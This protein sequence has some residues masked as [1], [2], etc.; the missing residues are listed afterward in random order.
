M[1]IILPAYSGKQIV[2]GDLRIFSSNRSF[3]F[4]KRMIEVSVNHLLLQIESNNFKLSCIRFWKNKF[5]GAYVIIVCFPIIFVFVRSFT[6]AR[7]SIL[8]KVSNNDTHARLYLIMCT[9]ALRK[10]HTHTRTYI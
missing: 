10:V 1:E 9:Y 8:K 3:L 7:L 4:K 6:F 2:N 5:V